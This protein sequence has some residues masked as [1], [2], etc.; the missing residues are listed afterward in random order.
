M[1]FFLAVIF[2]AL[3]SCALFPATIL[4]ATPSYNS[5]KS[6]WKTF[7]AIILSPVFSILYS[8]LTYKAFYHLIPLINAIDIDLVSIIF[9]VIATISPYFGIAY[10]GIWVYYIL[11]NKTETSK[12]IGDAVSIIYIAICV[13]STIYYI[14][15]GAAL[16]ILGYILAIILGLVAMHIYS[17]KLATEIRENDVKLPSLDLK[18]ENSSKLNA[19]LKRTTPYTDKFDYLSIAKDNESFYDLGDFC[20]ER[21]QTDDHGDL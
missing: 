10:V 18:R 7:L 12:T 19:P 1:D 9:L 14:Y 13:V 3:L 4:A 21:E 17:N 15:H 20:E 11:C 16:P 2:F 6:G 8:W 5:A